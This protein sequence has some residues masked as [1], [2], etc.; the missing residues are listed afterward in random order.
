MLTLMKKDKI[1]KTSYIIINNINHIHNIIDKI[2]QVLNINMSILINFKTIFNKYIINLN[3]YK[4]HK[5]IRLFI[6][7]FNLNNNLHKPQTLK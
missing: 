5:E 7:L 4:I 3:T 1:K 2:L 6:N